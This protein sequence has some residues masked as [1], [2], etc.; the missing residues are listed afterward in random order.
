MEAR[1]LTLLW[2]GYCLDGSSHKQL[3]IMLVISR[4]DEKPV[5]HA[6]PIRIM[7]HHKP[8][9]SAGHQ[10]L[11][12]MGIKSELQSLSGRCSRSPYPLSPQPY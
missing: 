8:E 2:A 9:I 11:T 7:G 5:N 10:Q 12:R 4:T 6:L 3:A 1:G